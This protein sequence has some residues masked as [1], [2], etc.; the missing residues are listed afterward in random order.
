MWGQVENTAKITI[1]KEVL[2]GLI[3]E[4]PDDAAV[5]L[6]A[7]GHRRKGDCHDLEELVPLAKEKMIAGIQALSPKGKTPISRSVR[8]TAERIKSLEDETSIILIS[9]GKETCDPDP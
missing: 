1:A 2:T 6:V 4:L 3:R 5:G 7:Y 9:D 8:L